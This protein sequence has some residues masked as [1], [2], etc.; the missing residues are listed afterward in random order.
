MGG[1]NVNKC[2][3]SQKVLQKLKNYTIHIS[4][5]YG[6]ATCCH[7]D[8]IMVTSHVTCCHGYVACCHDDVTCNV[9]SW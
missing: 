6:N 9:L 8:A 1:P 7:G 3:E 5:C 4:V 2:Y